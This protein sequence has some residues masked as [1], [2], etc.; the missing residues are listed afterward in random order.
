MGRKEGRNSWYG[1]YISVFYT[2]VKATGSWQRLN[3]NAARRM[4]SLNNI[5]TLTYI[6][7]KRVWKK[8]RI[9]VPRGASVWGFTTNASNSLLSLR[10]SVKLH[11]S[12]SHFIVLW[13]A[14]FTSPI[15]WLRHIVLKVHLLGNRFCLRLQKSKKRKV[16]LEY[17]INN[18]NNMFNF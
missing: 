6:C 5:I 10:C 13:H 11:I 17:S 8:V 1:G 16:Q 9:L 14:N 7:V 3:V 15:V 2:S 18:N 4:G 12:E